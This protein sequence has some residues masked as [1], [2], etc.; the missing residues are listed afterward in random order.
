M[1]KTKM[2]D[3]N[4]MSWI[5]ITVW[6]RDDYWFILSI[7]VELFN[8]LFIDTYMSNKLKLTWMKWGW[9]IVW[10]ETMMLGQYRR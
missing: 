7:K 5:R 8:D 10:E 3:D 2:W 1:A 6:N 9:M 4:E